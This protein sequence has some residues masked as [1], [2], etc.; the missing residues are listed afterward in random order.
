MEKELKIIY[1]IQTIDNDGMWYSIDGTFTDRLKEITGQSMP[2]ERCYFR[3]NYANLL[4]GVKDLDSL[5]LWFSKEQITKLLNSGYSLY[6]YKV[7]EYITLENGEVLFDPDKCLAQ[8]Q[9]L[10]IHDYGN[11]E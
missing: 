1:R 9:M 3:E 10:A 6:K 11:G 2:M 7:E 5:Y 4:S 8:Y